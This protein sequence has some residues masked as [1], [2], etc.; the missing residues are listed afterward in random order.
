V[1][2]HFE[3]GAGRPAAARRLR[4]GG[5]CVD[6]R[7]VRTHARAAPLLSGANA[8]WRHLL[9]LTHHFCKCQCM[10]QNL[11]HSKGRHNWQRSLWIRRC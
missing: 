3:V 5:C 7:R 6:L 1:R 8:F 4:G 9:A 2:Q 10:T 11:H